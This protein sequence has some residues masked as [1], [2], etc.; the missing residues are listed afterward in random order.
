MQSHNCS[1]AFLR[2]YGLDEDSTLDYTRA[3]TAV[4]APTRSFPARRPLFP[5]RVVYR[6]ES[7]SALSVPA[8]IL[9]KDVSYVKP[10]SLT[11]QTPLVFFE[12][13]TDGTAKH[14]TPQRDAM[15]SHAT[16]STPQNR[17]PGLIGELNMCTA[18]RYP[19]IRDKDASLST[20]T[21]VMS[22]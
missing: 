1:T 15:M 6:L 22:T 20:H 12:E 11:F 14:S 9:P 16:R 7:A 17:F 2:W 19:N 3:A 5:V 13:I 8:L 10:P 21:L 18:L 4:R